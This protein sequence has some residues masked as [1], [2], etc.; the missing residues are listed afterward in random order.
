VQTKAARMT[1]LALFV[2]LSGSLLSMIDS[3]VVNV[4]VPDISQQLGAP[5]TTVQWT[6][7]GYL[8]ALAAMLPATAFLGRRFGT[9]RIYGLSLAAF[10]LA[11]ALCALAQTAPELIA[12]RAVQG[13]AAAPLV[14]LSLNLLFGQS[15]EAVKD[16]PTS[17]GLVLFLGPALGPTIGGL[18]VSTWGWPSIFLVNLPIGAAALL[19]LRHLR[20]VGF[21]D[22]PERTARFDPLGL[23]MLSV[24]LTIAIYGTSQ[25]PSH[26]WWSRSASPYWVGG[27]LLLA[28]YTVWALRRRDPAVDLRLLR[29]ARSALSVTLCVL[30]S[31]AMFGV[32]FLLPVLVQEIQ[33]HSALA[34]GLVLLPQG[35]VMGLSTGVGRNLSG[36]RLRVAIIL[37]FAAIAA[38]SL[39][40]VVVQVDTPLWIVALVMA[41]RGLGVGLVIQPLLTGML[42]GLP[43]RE[44]AHANTLFN[45]GQRLGGSVGVS[46]LA[47]LF[48]IR[49]ADHVTA[50]LGPSAGVG[51]H[52]ASLSDVPTAVRSTVASAVLSGFHDTIWTAAAVAAV[53]VVG[54]LLLRVPR[55][56]SSADDA[57]ALPAEAVR[58]EAG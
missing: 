30:A 37:G 50:A 26:G 4:A 58:A 18:L 56:Q 12:F 44:L 23:A 2:L 39:L 21:V 42:G 1:P 27:V 53:G 9:V 25:A 6:V 33:G 15:E 34:A 17:A 45:V 48:S 36:V 31:V 10:T 20:R 57:G 47:T 11:S 16:L 14:P 38:T 41:G 43:K 24:G 28:A 40:L 8:L 7:S 13:L 35:V 32:L 19:G 54:A 3:S 52:I 46:L 55:S 49:V 51:S 22:E 29:T 5:L